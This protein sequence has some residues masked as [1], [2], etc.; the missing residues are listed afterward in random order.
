MS[1]DWRQAKDV[2]DRARDLSRTSREA[3]L[4]DQ[5]AQ[6]S[7][8]RAEVG[9]LLEA[10]DRIGN[11]LEPTSPD[12]GDRDSM[13]T[14]IGPYRVIREIGR[15]GMG[16]VF[17]GQRDASSEP[18]AIKLIRPGLGKEVVKRFRAE[19]RILAN[20]EHPH[21]ARLVDGGNT[22][23]G[24]PYLV[25][26]YVEG[27]TL[28]R[29]C[30]E[31]CL[32]IPQ[33]LELFRTVCSA[34]HFAHQNLIIHRDIKPG[35]ILVSA[36]GEPKLLDF[37]IAK[38]LD[39]DGHSGLA[40]TLR[41]E[42][43]M[44]PEYASPEQVRGRALTTATDVYALGVLLYR[45]LTGSRP[46]RLHGSSQ[47]ELEAAICRQDIER[48]S[49]AALR[50]SR[51][52]A[53]DRSE[54]NS[55]RLARRL[56]GELDVIVG[57]AMRKEPHRRYQSAERLSDDVRRYLHGLP[58]TVREDTWL[59]R[60]RKL[61][62]RHPATSVAACSAF[63]IM[64]VLI[65]ALMLQHGQLVQQRQRAEEALGRSETVKDFMVELFHPHDPADARPNTTTARRELLDAG[66]RRLETETDF[67]PETRAALMV[68]IGLGYRKLAHYREAE[69]L[70]EDA[71]EL[72]QGLFGVQH[73][74]VAES[75]AE[76]AVLAHDQGDFAEAESLARQALAIRREV[77]GGDHPDVA[78]SLYSLANVLLSRY[79][80]VD[81][82]PLL[83]EALAMRQRL[84]E[85]NHP[86]V[87]QS[88][89]A[90]ALALLP[91][92]E[93]AQARSLLER[94]LAMNRRL[95]GEI[96]PE[97]ARSLHCLGWVLDAQGHYEQAEALFRQAMVVRRTL[98][99][100]DHP[101]LAKS[102]HQLAKVLQS[103]GRYARA[104]ELF[105]DVLAMN[106]RLHPNEVH[107]DVAGSMN[108]LGQLLRDLA[109]PEA[110]EALFHRALQI[111]RQTLRPGH[112]SIAITQVH[113]GETLTSL[114]RHAEAE[115]YLREAVELHQRENDEA[116]L[117]T[118]R[119][120][121]AL[122]AALIE[123]GGW[124]EAE[125]M[126]RQALAALESV[127]PSGHWRVGVAQSILGDALARLTRYREAE[128][129]LRAGHDAIVA[130]RGERSQA[131][132]EARR[133]L[134]RLVPLR[135]NRAEVSTPSGGQI[136]SPRVGDA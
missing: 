102:T 70:L 129:L 24:R 62:A 132:R 43:P 73:P 84:A 64:T 110:A 57:C 14:A 86:D 42:R 131:S 126:G 98:Y 26:E 13:P 90:L 100:G 49:I 135:A 33:R 125:S 15:G 77:H 61:A 104:E 58:L 69:P 93:L 114:G 51:E 119:A 109:R 75:L 18:V 34:V 122:A 127:L 63:L 32:S 2:F 53:R 31:R 3:L 6:D 115:T 136:T 22:E 46:Y 111:N 72:R 97:V 52:T 85:G 47:R 96:H 28:D 4:A 48:P 67:E 116:I 50:A 89:T 80:I 39:P 108:S 112:P 17:L 113:L 123:Q 38:L 106:T 5:C 120:L 54:D 91:R 35:N 74:A 66:V 130:G 40:A 79:E 94:A 21:I 81:A 82:E 101:S 30:D 68:A 55:R 103:Q 65:T 88:L 19:R 95:R 107:P 1:F 87:A 133:R 36:A 121:C 7:N 71:L 12:T 83:H 29:Y 23:D 105:R 134:D 41:G 9:V 10:H 44:T 25:V 56:A 37:G 8:L 117:A 11:F 124:T 45:L 60:L 118:S 128:P 27:E 16:V 99:S 20:L 92:G 59:Y 78:T 76:L